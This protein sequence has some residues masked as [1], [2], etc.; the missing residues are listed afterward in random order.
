MDAK[1]D[2]MT[3]LNLLRQRDEMA[4]TQLV[5]QYHPSLVRLARLFVQDETIAEEIS[6]ET[7]LAVLQG[8]S[9][10]E[11]RSSLKTWLFTI[12]TNKARTRSRRE[13][14]SFVFSD[15]DN[16]ATSFESSPTVDPER[17]KDAADKWPNHWL[18]DAQPASWAGI[19]ED[20]LLSEETLTL[21]RQTIEG[22]PPNQRS[23]ITLHDIDEL[24]SQE[25]CNI[26][27]ISETNQRVLLH[28]ARAKVRQA[29][30]DY[31]Q[32]EH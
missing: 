29:L 27:E 28:R 25:I 20:L 32:P 5:E 10:F 18:A 11:E 6:Q 22:L 19:P 1:L 30:E 8:L 23:V 21:V 17:F 14:R 2:E 31:L 16:A 12:L 7:W 9:H 26:L 3:L 13:N 24:S 15:F 4:F